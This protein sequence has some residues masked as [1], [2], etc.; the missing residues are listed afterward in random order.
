[1]Q[2]IHPIHFEIPSLRGLARHALPN[3]LEATFIPLGVFLL[4]LHFLGVWGSMATGLIWVYGS[5][6]RR[7][8]TRRR[9]PGILA[10]GALTLTARTIIAVLSGSVFVYFLQP[11]LGTVLVA[12]AFLLSVP[13]GR[14]LAQKLAHDFLPMSE[15]VL[16]NQHVRRFFSQ[17]TL[18]W[19]FA[20]LTNAA[21]TIWLLLSQSIGTYVVAKTFVSL[22]LS[23]LAIGLST[24][25]FHRT[26][27]RHGI[28]VSRRR[29]V[30]V[31]VAVPVVPHSGA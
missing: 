14:P 4:T 11:S 5:I 6:V 26:M 24:L 21:L 2:P 1:M 7:L 31:P 30:P 18:L 13:F 27:R 25:W 10:I 12:S 3:L 22:G 17:I 20:Q 15:E 16:T 19:A 28:D 9:V 29:P 8:V 23:G